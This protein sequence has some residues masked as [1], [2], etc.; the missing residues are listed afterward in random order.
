MW[1]DKRYTRVQ[2]MVV[3]LEKW[4]KTKP[5]NL[6]NRATRKFLGNGTKSWHVLTESLITLWCILNYHGCIT[7]RASASPFVIVQVVKLV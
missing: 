3:Q 1:K 5:L 6:A 2:L 7:G 4:S